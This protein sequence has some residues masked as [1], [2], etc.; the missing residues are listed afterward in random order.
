MIATFFLENS[1]V[2]YQPVHDLA[3]AEHSYR[4]L[5][6]QDLKQQ[7]FWGI[8]IICGAKAKLTFSLPVW[9]WTDGVRYLFVMV[10]EKQSQ[11]NRNSW[12]RIH[13]NWRVCICLLVCVLSLTSVIYHMWKKYLPTSPQEVLHTNRHTQASEQVICNHNNCD[14]HAIINKYIF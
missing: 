7:T 13:S 11:Y 12:S 6:F 8:Q 4:M 9:T 14:Y 2:L 1:I 3:Y 10:P 5:Y